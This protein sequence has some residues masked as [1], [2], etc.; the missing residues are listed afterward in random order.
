VPA[1]APDEDPD[2]EEPET[3]VSADAMSASAGESAAVTV[4]DMAST[5]TRFETR[6]RVSRIKGTA[7]PPL[8]VSAGTRPLPAASG[9]PA[10]GLVASIVGRTCSDAP[11]PRT[12]RLDATGRLTDDRIAGVLGW[13][14]GTRLDVAFDGAVAVFRAA[15]DGAPE[16]TNRR[17]HVASKGVVVSLGIRARLGLGDRAEVAVWADAAEGTLTVAPAGYLTTAVAAVDLVGELTADLDAAQA[18]VA[19][20]ERLVAHLVDTLPEEAAEAS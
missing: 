11:A 13:T 17:P 6:H 7:V 19:E 12:R 1:Q 8:P 20:L 16:G 15:P 2:P 9:R 3:D 10:E 18:R 5:T 4:D 14:A